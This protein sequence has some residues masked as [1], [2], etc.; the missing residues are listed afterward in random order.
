MIRYL[1][2]D[3][4]MHVVRRLG[5]TPRDAGLLASALARPAASFGGA[6]FYDSLALKAAVILES[7][8]RGHP[9]IDGNKRTGWTL[10]VLFLWINGRRHDLGADAAFDL[11]LGV[12]E[13][14]VG[15]DESADLL[16]AGLVPR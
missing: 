5:F 7:V 1:D 14:R 16:A 2:L 15:L 6:D 8:V 12:A 11:V 3:D 4:A 13:G 9:L 10:A